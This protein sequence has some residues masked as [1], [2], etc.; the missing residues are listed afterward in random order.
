[1]RIQQF[2]SSKIGGLVARF[3]G[4]WIKVYREIIGTDISKN[5]TRLSLFIHLVAFA[6][7]EETW[8]EWNGKPR[9]CPRGSLV[10]SYR[11]L[12]REI[13]TDKGTVERQLKYLALRDTVVVETET[14]GT[15]ITVKNYSEYQDNKTNIR[16][17]TRHSVDTGADTGTDTDRDSNE[18]SKN[19]RSKEDSITSEV[20]KEPLSLVPAVIPIDSKALKKEATER[21]RIARDAYIQA[22]RNRYAK[23]PIQDAQ[24]HS[25][26]GKIVKRVGPEDAARI[27][28][29]YVHHNKPF[30]AEKCHALKFCLADIES[31]AVQ[32]AKGKA[33][34]KS[35][36]K[37]FEEQTDI[38]QLS[39]E[40]IAEIRGEKVKG[41]LNG[42]S[43][44]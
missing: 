12:A 11:E 3:D 4:G 28:D 19:I 41:M 14:R 8:V 38:V 16:T 22:Y 18:E 6:N 29:F 43:H 1:M 23:D 33:I 44:Q 40:D 39:A 9:V 10:T 32:T 20:P 24:F 35:D 13:G 31:L 37:R 42:P 15:F 17:V 7:I 25:I 26:I 2:R 36:L 5:P 30:Y 27:L 34:L 21:N